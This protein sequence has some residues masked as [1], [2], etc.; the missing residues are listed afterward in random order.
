MCP[1]LDNS[2]SRLQAFSFLVD[3]SMGHDRRA[4]AF[5]N[6]CCSKQTWLRV[7]VSVSYIAIPLKIPSSGVNENRRVVRLP[8]LTRRPARRWDGLGAEKGPVWP[9]AQSMDLT[10][11]LNCRLKSRWITA[12]MKSNPSSIV[13]LVGALLLM[14]PHPAKA[15]CGDR[16][17]GLWG[18]EVSFGPEVQGTLTIYRRAA[19][20]TASISGID[21]PI[22][23]DGQ[24]LRFS[25]PG[26][27]GEFRGQID[28]RR[29]RI[30]GQWIQPILT[31]VW[32]VSYATPV[33]LAVTGQDVWR[34]AVLNLA[35]AESIYLMIGRNS[36]GELRSFVRSP[37][38]NLGRY[39]GEMRVKCDED[40]I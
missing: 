22:H 25:L 35:D 27:R 2:G 34:G 37:E 4:D 5:R 19:S 40:R 12:C 7:T 11:A 16:L 15:E 39:L 38:R 3:H 31:H 8:R 33:E 13:F 30:Q 29:G 36:S 10:P 24:H 6:C 21:V 9:A 32:G 28:G 23:V 14:S 20:W 17:T 18:A 26:G 1:R